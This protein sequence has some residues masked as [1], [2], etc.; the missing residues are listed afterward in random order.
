M[1][2]IPRRKIDELIARYKLEPELKDLYVE[3][4]FDMKLFR[5]ITR[6]LNL[7]VSVYTIDTVEC[8]ASS[9][10]ENGLTDNTRSRVVFVAQMLTKTL[11]DDHAAVRLVAD[12]D[13]DSILGKPCN[14]GL[15]LMTDCTSL[16]A[17]FFDEIK[18]E[19]FFLDSFG[20]KISASKLHDSMLAV[21]HKL[22][23]ARAANV[24]LDWGMQWLEPDK[25]I[26]V[27][28]GDEII[29]FNYHEFERRYLSKNSRLHD[30]PLFQQKL[31]EIE[32]RANGEVRGHDVF[33]LLAVW[34]KKQNIDS[35][36]CDPEVLKTL[37]FLQTHTQKIIGY[38]LFQS[39]LSW[40]GYYQ[41]KAV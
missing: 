36:F 33:E 12:K 26:T 18:N 3:G 28:R 22:F 10:M 34:L 6:E 32:P 23:L 7:N 30:R 11:G 5:K 39:I 4:N 21:L 19:F 27:C 14:R 25:C 16:E 8:P 29:G 15:L 2:D 31:L 9:L 13:F 17:Y 35:N 37:L 38:S 40:C 20:L 41:I 24:A 1:N